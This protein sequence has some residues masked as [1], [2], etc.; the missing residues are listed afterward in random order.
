MTRTYLALERLDALDRAGDPLPAGV[1]SEPVAPCSVA[2]SRMLYDAVGRDYHWVDRHA[3]SDEYLAAF[4]ARPSH[5]VWTLHV[6]DTLAGYFELQSCP[7]GSTQIQYLGLLPAFH[8]RGL[9][10]H[11]LAEAVRRA[12]AQAPT[13]VWL[14]TCTL[15]H[16]AALP[17]YL[18]RG[19]RPFKEERYFQEL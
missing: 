14:H 1:R 12:F 11:L 17:N 10:R 16:P 2:F 19:F 5:T 3:W 13:R 4:L 15:D 6:D 7:D 8:G 18:K 9:G